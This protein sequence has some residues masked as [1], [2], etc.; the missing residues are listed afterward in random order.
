VA[1]VG[2]ADKAA[3]A[4]L[5]IDANLG[6][7]GVERVLEQFLDDGRRAFDYLAGGDFV[8]D[9]VGKNPDAP[10]TSI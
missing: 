2:D 6:G 4:G 9:V 3:A 5:D 10:Q 1:V 7:A 8:G